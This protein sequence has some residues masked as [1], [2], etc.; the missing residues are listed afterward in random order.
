MQVLGF[1]AMPIIAFVILIISTIVFLASLYKRCP[2]DQ[3]LVIYGRVGE[4]QSA[5][6]L[7]GGGALVWPLIQDYAY[8]HLT[9]MTISIP[10]QKAL[11]RQN[12][13]ID[14]PSTFTVGIS[15]DPGIMNNAAERLLTLGQE[16]VE[17]MAMEIIFGQLRLTVASLTIEQI[18]QDRESFLEAIRKNVSPELNKIGLDLINVNITDIT[19][20][21]EYIRS[22]GKKAAAEAINQAKID[23]AEQEKYGEIGEA[24]AIRQKEIKVSENKAEAEKGKKRAEADKRVFLQ[25]QESEA[26]IGETRADREKDI[27]VAENMAEADKGKKQAEADKRIFVQEQ[28]AQAVSG[29]N[30]AKADIADADAKLAIKQANAMKL[31]EVAKRNAEAEIQKAQYKA[32]Q[33]RLN[34]E[35]VVK[36]EIQKRKV[37]I[38]AEAEAEKIRREARGAA[39]ATLMQYE[40]EAKGIRQVL[41]S[42]ASGYADLIKS[43][44]DDSKSVA[45]FLMIEKIEE[46]ITMQVEAIKNLKIDKVTVWDSGS[47]EKGSGTTADFMSGLIKSLPPLHSIAKTAGLELPEYL[48][49]VKGIEGEAAFTEKNKKNQSLKE[50]AADKK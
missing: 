33:E 43:C 42:K 16:Q 39:D 8:M 36:E 9:P 49:S 27:K 40:S 48:G 50:A 20:E 21:S 10:L 7:H 6:C 47:T 19:D 18:N 44:N 41:A 45:T 23:V 5:N 14:V 25:Q 30:A 28:E 22:I 35:E 38:A 1:W 3:I 32:E 26:I 4:G 46:L 34:A 31:G 29:E 13:R 37:E 11:S 12:I 24:E 17:E 15:T 2:S